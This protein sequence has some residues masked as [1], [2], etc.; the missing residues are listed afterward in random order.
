MSTSALPPYTTPLQKLAHWSL[1][2]VCG[3]IFCS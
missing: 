3:A 1:L 2:L